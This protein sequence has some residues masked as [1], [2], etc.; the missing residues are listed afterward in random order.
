M[1]TL[2]FQYP[3][4][5]APGP[6]AERTLAECAER[7]AGRPLAV[8]FRHPGWWREDRDARTA[9]LLT[10]L[11]MAAVAVDTAQGLPRSMPPVAPVTVDRLAVVRFHGRSRAWGNGSKEDKFRHAYTDAELAEWLP[12]IRAMSERAEEL[13]VLFNNCCAD[14]AVGAAESMSRL[15]DG[16]PPLDAHSGSDP[17]PLFDVQPLFDARPLGGTPGNSPDAGGV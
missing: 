16:R 10:D 4:W 15:L 14:A 9:A 17:Q 5:F 12:R 8:E 2:L 3:P 7:A 13:H 11:G 6:R 1:G